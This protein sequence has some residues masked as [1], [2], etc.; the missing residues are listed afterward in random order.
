MDAAFPH[1]VC[2]VFVPVFPPSSFVVAVA[3]LE[4]VP[5][6]IDALGAWAALL[7]SKVA[8][9]IS[10]TFPP[11]MVMLGVFP[12]VPVPSKYAGILRLLFVTGS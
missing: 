8:V 12:S 6:V 4:A 11:S 9:L 2:C 1:S 10:P 7:P 3:V 5:P